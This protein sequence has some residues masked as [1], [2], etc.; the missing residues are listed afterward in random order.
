[1][2]HLLIAGSTGSGKSVLLHIIIDSLIS[3]MSKKM[4]K[5][6]LID[7]KRVELKYFAK[8]K[9]LDGKV[10]VEYEEVLRK[11]LWLVDEMEIRYKKLEKS[12]HRDINDY[13]NLFRE[14]KMPYIVT[15]IDEFA[16]MM[17]RSK[18]EEKK[19]SI[20]Y[21]SKTKGWIHK[22]LLKR[23]N[24]DHEIFIKDD[25]GKERKIIIGP[26]RDYSK[27]DLIEIMETLDSQDVINRPD[28]NVEH[29]I[30]RLAA[31]G[32]AVGIHIIIA[33]QRPSVDVITGLIKSNISCRIALTTASEI[34]S[35][36]IIDQAGAEKLNGK[37]DLLYQHPSKP[38]TRLQGF[39]I[40]NYEQKSRNK[41]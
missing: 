21:S 16:D 4:M 3:Q 22:Q 2:P 28:A 10:L 9:N 41:K 27:D 29:L 26:M 1:M 12:M 39:M 30:T 38:L 18:V 37:G 13:N 25:D 14:E 8:A 5:L 15:V 35:R 36:I 7:P 19:Q 33:T 23:A 34:D 17:L 11:L 6:I 40:Q 32:R 20:S 24:K 31:M